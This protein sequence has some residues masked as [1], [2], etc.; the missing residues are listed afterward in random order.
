M[1][2]SSAKSRNQFGDNPG[3]EAVILIC[4]KLYFHDAMRIV[5]NHNDTGTEQCHYIKQCVITCI[6]IQCKISM[7][8]P[9]IS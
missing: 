9:D 6:E 1:C 7:T 3:N 8:A 4:L 5:A 2:Y